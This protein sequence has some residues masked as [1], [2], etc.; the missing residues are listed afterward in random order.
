MLE[1]RFRHITIMNVIVVVIAV[2]VAVAAVVEF[3]VHI[4][5]AVAVV[6]SHG[7]RSRCYGYHIVIIQWLWSIL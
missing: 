1:L 2:T 5:A 7:R 3:I 4:A 6:Q